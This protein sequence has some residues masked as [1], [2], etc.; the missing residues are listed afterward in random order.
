MKKLVLSERAYDDL[1]QI[2]RY[3]ARDKLQAAARFVDQLE[4]QCEFLARCPHSGTKRG[5]LAPQLR[6]FTFRGYGIYF[7]EL[8]DR[9]RIERVLPPGLD[10]SNQLFD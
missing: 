2:L 10:V 4:A 8:T 3:I 1:L 7:R 9:V 5:D 6:L